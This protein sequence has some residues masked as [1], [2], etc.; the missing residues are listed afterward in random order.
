M[1][2][3][4]DEITFCVL[5]KL[6]AVALIGAAKE[7]GQQGGQIGYTDALPYSSAAALGLVLFDL[8]QRLPQ[9]PDPSGI[10]KAEVFLPAVHFRGDA[11]SLV[12]HLFTPAGYEISAEPIA[13]E[14]W[15]GRPTQFRALRIEG[16]KHPVELIRELAVLLAALDVRSHLVLSE[17][18]GAIRRD[19]ENVIGLHPQRALILDRL[20]GIDKLPA[21]RWDARHPDSRRSKPVPSLPPELQRLAQPG[22]PINTSIVSSIRLQPEQREF[23]AGQLA[24]TVD[25]RW[26]MYLPPPVAAVQST[27]PGS[28]LEHPSDAFD[29]YRNQ[30][31]QK[32]VMEVKHMG[33]RAIVVVCK[34]EETARTRFQ[35]SNLGCVYTRNGRPFFADPATEAE[36]LA[37]LRA[38]LTR[39][40]FWQRLGT[41]WACLDGELM[42]W[43]AKAQRLFAALR[44]GLLIPGQSASTEA[45]AALNEAEESGL[46]VARWKAWVLDRL[47]AIGQTQT[48]LAHYDAPPDQITFAPFHLLATEGQ[49]CTKRTHLWHMEV[50]SKAARLGEGFLLPTPFQVVDLTNAES[51]REAVAWWNE[52]IESGGEGVVI[53]PLPFVPRGR[54]GLCQPALKC[55]TP[56]HLRLVYGPEYD[57]PQNLEMLRQRGSLVHRRNKHRRVLRQF[58]LSCE[59]IERAVRCAPLVE[60]QECILGLLALEKSPDDSE[61]L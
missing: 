22:P 41:N 3:T 17:A 56:E 2:E 8:L 9:N 10:S 26:L 29:Y 40:Q 52:I 4:G 20:Q 53:K 32:A 59:A 35:S 43:T 1:A 23:A 11:E 27:K 48:V 51:E 6:K 60:V 42:P 39:G 50:L 12:R 25:H 37:R 33:S 46:P 24:R 38:V 16:T 44:N 49:N 18:L 34:D 47:R 28:V 31:I 36:F 13:E 19:C 7:R 14:F 58:A 45:L 15:T 61:V 5:L 30:G 21:I 57:F 55:R 54:R